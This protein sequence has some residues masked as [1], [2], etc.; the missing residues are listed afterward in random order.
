PPPEPTP[1]EAPAVEQVR[2]MIEAQVRQ[3]IANDPGTRLGQDPE[4]L[5][6]MR[7]ACPRLRTLLR[8]AA[9]VLDPEWVEPLREEIGWLGDELGAV[10]DLDVLRQHM[11]DEI[12]ALAPG[13]AR[14]G[15]PL[16]P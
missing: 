11:S 10:R 3:I 6:Q 1:P 5:H 7:V 13:A 12:A 14:G 15:A 2:A 4:L 8:E 9:S 16:I